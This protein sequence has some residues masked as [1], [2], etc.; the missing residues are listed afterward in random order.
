ML[1]LIG[2]DAKAFTERQRNV[3]DAARIRI[4]QRLPVWH[5][6]LVRWLVKLATSK[7]NVREAARS[8]LIAHSGVVR[9][10]VLNLAEQLSSVR[11]FANTEYVFI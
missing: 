8:A 9:R 10:L 6:W 4:R 2:C 3:R 5:R 1:S 7:R 11:I